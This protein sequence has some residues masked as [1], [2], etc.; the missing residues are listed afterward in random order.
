MHIH[1]LGNFHLSFLF[2]TL[3]ENQYSK[4]TFLLKLVIQILIYF[5][6]FMAQACNSI[7]VYIYIYDYVFS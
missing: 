2:G 3:S 1:I 4:N 5:W 7:Y 6:L